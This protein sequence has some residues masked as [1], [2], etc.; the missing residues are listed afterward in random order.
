MDAVFAALKKTSFFLS[1]A[2][3]A[4]L[5]RLA[6]AATPN[7]T[8][9]TDSTVVTLVNGAAFIAVT[10]SEDS[11]SG[12]QP[13]SFT[14]SV[15]YENGD[16]AWLAV[17]ADAYGTCNGGS[18]QYTTPIPQMTMG[19][20]CQAGGLSTTSS[21]TALVTFNPVSA[22][23]PGVSPVTFAVIYNLSGT[24]TTTLTATPGALTGATALSAPFGGQVATNVV[25]STTSSSPVSFTISTSPTVSWLT[26]SPASGQVSSAASANLKVTASAVGL[27]AG[28]QSTTIV[29]S[30][31]G[32]SFSI[33]V[34]FTVNQGTV[35][36]SPATLA[37]TY[38]SGTLSPASF[39]TVT[40][41]TQNSDTYTV[42]VSYPSGQT[43]TNWLLVNGGVSVTGLANG[44]TFSV[45]VTNY[46]TLASGTYTGTI[47]ATDNSNSGNTTTL[48]V[49][50]AVSAAPSGNLTVTPNPVGLNSTNNYSQ[51]VTVTSV[52]GGAFTVTPY[53]TNSW[54]SVTP[55]ANTI[56]AG[57]TATVSVT[58]NTSVVESGSYGG[59]VTITVGTVTQVVT[60]N[61]TAGSG[62]GGGATGY[63]APT[64][65]NFVGQSGGATVTQQV[66]FAGN[67]TFNIA[68]SP[69]YSANSGSVAWLISSSVSGNMV[70]Q[71][72]KVTFYANPKN[73]APGTYT[74]SVALG[75]TIN[76]QPDES[77][78]TF[79]VNFVVVSGAVLTASPTTVLLNNGAQNATISVSSTGSTALPITVS[80]DQTWLGATIQGGAT[81]TPATISVAVSTAGLSNGMY[82]GNVL[83]SSTSAQTLYVPVVV[84][85]T[86]GTNP[87]GLTLSSST[88]SFSAQV[89]GSAPNQTLT[90][91]SGTAGLAFSAS[92]TVSSPTGGTWLSITPSGNLTTNQALTVSVKPAGLPVGT[93]S[94]NI[95]LTANEITVNVPVSLVL[96]TTAPSG[97][98][99]TVSPTALNFSGVSGEA[100]PAT[101]TL[102]V[103]STSGSAGISFTAVASSTGN[104]LSVSPGSGTTQDVLTVSVNQTNLGIGS[105]TGTI[106]ITPNGGSEVTVTVTLEVVAQPTI[107]VT[108]LLLSFSFQAGSG[109]S[110]TPGQLSVAATG[111]TVNFQASASSNGNWLSV[112]PT[113]GSTSTSA[114][115]TVSVNPAGLA[116]S[117]TPYTGT[118]TIDGVSGTAGSVTVDVSLT[119][120]SPLPNITSVLNAGSYLGGPIAPGEIVSIFGTSIGPVNPAFLT[121]DSTGKVSTSLGGVTVSF[122][123]Y[124]APLTYVSS[125]QINAIV[126]YELAGRSSPF[127]EVM[128]A[129]QKSN[130]PALQLTTTA[131]GIFTQNS[132]GT[133]LGAIL[134][135][136][137]QVN[138]SQNPAAPGSTIQIYLTGEG[139]TTPAQADGAVTPVNT[140]GV[141]PLTPAPQLAVSVMIG[142]QIAQVAFAGEAPDFVAGVLQVNA[143]VPATASSGADSITVQVGQNIS[144]NGVTVWVQ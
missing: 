76:G 118:I 34:T 21:H 31:N 15:A 102:T 115:L 99:V 141:G 51:V 89:G 124:P 39:Q 136:N 1:L 84:V 92:A 16:P 69:T 128:F 58:A 98:N 64:T 73:L 29:V 37:W 77:A 74:A 117:A 35:N 125:T 88:M 43:A 54:L 27:A 91:S 138:S 33:P 61:L 129:G 95:A 66:V 108:P 109:G 18:Y 62:A 60:V 100:A 52:S 131:P 63:V 17:G 120:T 11:G 40:L 26:V 96:T 97:G 59:T 10:G 57:G 72:S 110:V 103:S 65:L 133:G 116:A 105:H 121:L 53:P 7:F 134:N 122:S 50:L 38:A 13:I 82:A 45:A 5:P 135:Q 22:L 48:T 137:N 142:G 56:V 112:T 14:V 127:V 47:T 87:S 113:S 8:N 44:S 49:T 25:L 94:G 86:G 139:L 23:S 71:G 75:L 41:V 126:P 107:T 12:A 93:Y 79:A 30:Y 67:G 101:Q 130:E 6:Q 90:V 28:S 46:S 68:T 81:T 143:V 32:Q 104:W 78:P 144:Q 132:S 83:V 114:P 3:L 9:P 4:A 85:I 36:L 42:Q 123:G 19:V 140:S 80:T 2:L 20:S 111:G 119:V 24:G 106:T 70:P 55:S